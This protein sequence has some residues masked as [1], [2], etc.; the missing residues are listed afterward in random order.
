MTITVGPD[1]VLAAR[2][3]GVGVGLGAPGRN[4]Q[5][6]EVERTNSTAQSAARVMHR[7]TMWDI[8]G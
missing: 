5:A 2:A 6:T 1:D 3:A 4:E 7:E 8:G